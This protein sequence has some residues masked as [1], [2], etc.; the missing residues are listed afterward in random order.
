M[1]LVRRATDGE[2]SII[3]SKESVPIEFRA[4]SSFLLLSIG[5]SLQRT[6]DKSRFIN[7]HVRPNKGLESFEKRDDAANKLAGISPGK[8]IARM[9]SL[10]S[11]M[12]DQGESHSAKAVCT[13][14]TC[15][16]TRRTAG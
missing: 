1:S 8:L 9:M 15:R 12:A 11:V 5:N 14:G 2:T 13:S 16:K 4:R 3:G 6:A 10:A 7:L